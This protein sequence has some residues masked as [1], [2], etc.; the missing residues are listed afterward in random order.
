MTAASPPETDVAR[1]VRWCRG[2]VPDRV[3][4]RVR[5][6][7]EVAGRDV[8]I[9]ERH[10]PSG[11][12]A[13]PDW[14]TTPVARLRYLKSRGVWRLYWPGSDERWHEYPDLP[15]ARDVR[16]LLEEIDGDPTALFWG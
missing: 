15:F 11:P 8:T 12:H 16:D 1:V 2:R 3:R 4:D 5:V 14:S 9:V 7:C 10:R 13:G 6:D